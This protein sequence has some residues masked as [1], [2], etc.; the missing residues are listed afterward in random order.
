L[1][2][3]SALEEIWHVRF[4]PEM[5]KQRPECAGLFCACIVAACVLLTYPVAEMGF[6]D[7]WSYVRTALDF[8]R[9]GHFVY[10]GWATAMLGWIIPWSA[11]FIKVFG[12][13]FTLVRFSMLPVTM[14]CIYLF[15]ANLVRFGIRDRNAVLGA[16]TV[17][18]SPVFLPMAASYMTDVAG[19]FVIVLCLY[20]CQRAVAAHSDRAAVLW[21]CCAAATNVAGGTVRQISWLGA[22]VMV[23]STAWLLRRRRGVLATGISLWVLSIVSVLAC[24]HWWNSQPYSVPEHILHGPV[25]AHMVHHLVGILIKSFLCLLLLLYP[26][27]IAWLPAARGL[28]RTATIRVGVAILALIVFLWKV[29]TPDDWLAPWLTHVIQSLMRESGEFPGVTETPWSLPVRV[30]ISV[31]VVA[32]ALIVGEVIYP[33]LRSKSKNGSVLRLVMRRDLLWLLGPFSLSYI[34]MLL[35]RGLYALLY[36][37]YLLG[38]MPLGIIF[39][40]R[41][42]QQVIGANL[43]AISFVMLGAFGSFSIASTHDW[44]ALNR[45]RIVAV[46]EVRATGVPKTAI[47]G[48]FEYDGWTQIEAAGFV[49]EER[50]E[51][52]AGAFHKN[53]RMYRLPERCWHFFGWYAPAIDPKYLIVSSPSPCFADSRFPAVTFRTWLPPFRRTIYVQQMK[54]GQK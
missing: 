15:H 8:A 6:Q 37:R 50:I 28:N 30:A 9:T 43:P 36:D 51:V 25:T 5:C 35:P 40:I 21:L 16:L 32:S 27:L 1:R 3:A 45:A 14:A 54:S 49:N 2:K 4:L 22:L 42:Y 29:R 52:P 20:L 31:L 12:F 38:L 53:M 10:N 17:G 48:A 13:S 18:L 11:L 23:P 41:L 33:T 39:L 47:Q 19:L 24:L 26:I 7:D 44:F 34:V 46:E